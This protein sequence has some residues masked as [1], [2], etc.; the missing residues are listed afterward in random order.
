MIKK[1]WVN[2]LPYSQRISVLIGSHTYCWNK[3]SFKSL[4]M[5]S[6]QDYNN[7]N[8]RIYRTWISLLFYKR[9]FQLSEYKSRT[10]FWISTCGK[11]QNKQK[12]FHLCE[13]MKW[14]FW[15]ENCADL[16]ES[17]IISSTFGRDSH[18]FTTSK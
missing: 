5:L 14:Q 17:Q 7:P 10:K 8:T 12:S 11:F 6:S 4:I 2:V 1:K 13:C 16:S 15:T 18:Y 9:L 3:S